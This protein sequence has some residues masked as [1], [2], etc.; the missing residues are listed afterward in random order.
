V[1]APSPFTHQAEDRV[2]LLGKLMA[3][4]RP[5]FRVDV[6]TVGRA[7]CVPDGVVNSGEQ[8][9]PVAVWTAQ[10]DNSVGCPTQL[11]ASH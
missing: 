7:R 1:S 8:G 5:E 4:V 3:A 10:P 11:R 6:L 9:P 2:G